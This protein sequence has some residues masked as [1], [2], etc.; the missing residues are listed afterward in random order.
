M[1][2]MR[3]AALKTGFFARISLASNL[4]VLAEAAKERQKVESFKP[5]LGAI[6]KSRQGSKELGLRCFL[7]ERGSEI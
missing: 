3:F 4:A 5:A 6:V 2:E 1:K 7:I